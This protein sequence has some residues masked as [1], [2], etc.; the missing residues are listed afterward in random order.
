MGSADAGADAAGYESAEDVRTADIAALF[1]GL[2]GSN[3]RVTRM[4][5]DI[6]HAAM[7]KD[8]VLAASSDQSEVSN[9][10]N[11]T[12]SVNLVCPVY[13]SNYCGPSGGASSSGGAQYA[14]DGSAGG[15][16][17]AAGGAP[18]AAGGSTSGST[19]AAGGGG[20]NDGGGGCV[21]S[22]Q[23][24][25][26]LAAGFGAIGALLGLALVRVRTR[27]RSARRER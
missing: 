4:R 23:S 14:A 24:S 13:G 2:G 17:D 12:K 8:F 3:V 25:A 9:L 10:R 18:N 21:A 27:R 11:V 26:G 22:P 1:A 20:L 16:E 7:T 19:A 15:T 5:S 6:S